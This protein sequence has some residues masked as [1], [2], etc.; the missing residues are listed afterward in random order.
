MSPAKSK[1]LVENIEKLMMS[2]SWIVT[3]FVTILL[4]TDISMRALL[5]KPLPASYEISE[6]LM[7]Y[8][9]MFAFPYALTTG[10]HVR[11]TLLTE[12]L[13]QKAQ[14]YCEVLGNTLSLI[15]CVLLTYWSWLRFWESFLIREEILAPVSIPWWIGKFGMPIA[16]GMFGLR[17]FLRLIEGFTH[18][19]TERS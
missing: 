1:E 4:V 11:V 18:P 2:I 19:S 10:F 6:V 12:R 16:F 3:L 9:V 14:F 15:I 8:I 17:F 13:G 7:P 5:G